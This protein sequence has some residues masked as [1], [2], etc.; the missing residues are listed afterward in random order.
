LMER[1]WFGKLVVILGLIFPRPEYMRWRYKFENDWA[2]PVW[3]F[4]RWWGILRD[5][6]R[7]INILVRR[8]KPAKV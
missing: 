6:L 7:T 2:L 8:S 3:Y 4:Y 5:V 1:K